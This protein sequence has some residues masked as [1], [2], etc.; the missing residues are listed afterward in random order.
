MNIADLA[1]HQV[2]RAD[3]PAAVG[4]TNRLMAETYPENRQMAIGLPDKIK[5]DARLIGGAGAGGQDNPVNKPGF[6]VGQYFFN[7]DG[8]IAHDLY[9]LSYFAQIVKQVIGKAVIIIDQIKHQVFFAAV[10]SE[11]LVQK[12]GPCRK[13]LKNNI[14]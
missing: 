8:I 9:I 10:I 3:N 6:S 7:R 5:A 13:Q 11:P 12:K 2:R 14:V 4:L 1:M